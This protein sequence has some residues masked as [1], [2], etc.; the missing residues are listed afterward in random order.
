MLLIYE[1]SCL[2]VTPYLAEKSIVQLQMLN[3]IGTHFKWRIDQKQSQVWWTVHT[4]AVVKYL[5]RVLSLDETNKSSSPNLGTQFCQALSS[6]FSS[7]MP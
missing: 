2:P 1:Y 3:A 7:L 5:V 6:L 4:F